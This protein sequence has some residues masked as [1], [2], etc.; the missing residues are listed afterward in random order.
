MLAPERLDRGR[1]RAAFLC[2]RH[3]FGGAADTKRGTRRR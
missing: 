2:R 1:V 3:G